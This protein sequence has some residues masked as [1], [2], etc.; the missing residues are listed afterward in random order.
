[1]KNLILQIPSALRP[2]AE[3]LIKKL[4]ELEKK[5]EKLENSK[6]TSKKK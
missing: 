4:E 6:D 1:M 3:A 2:F 5:V